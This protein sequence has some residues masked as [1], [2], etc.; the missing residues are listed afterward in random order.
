[1]KRIGSPRNVAAAI[2]FLTSDEGGFVTGQ[3]ISV[4]DGLTMIWRS[5]IIWRSTAAR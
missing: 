4:S 3:A 1:M 2:A 5:Y